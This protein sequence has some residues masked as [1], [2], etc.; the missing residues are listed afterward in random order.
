MHGIVVAVRDARVVVRVPRGMTILDVVGDHFTEVGDVLSGDF[1]SAAGET[2]HNETNGESVVAFVGAAES[3][4]AAV[5]DD[6]SAGS[7]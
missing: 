1:A 2:L 4:I 7:A 6:V 3:D 5:L